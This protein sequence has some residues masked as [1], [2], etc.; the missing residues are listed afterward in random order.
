MTTTRAREL[1]YV[2]SAIFRP[3]LALVASTAHMLS[4]RCLELHPA[5]SM[6]AQPDRAE[7]AAAMARSIASETR[8]ARAR[9]LLC[10]RP[11]VTLFTI[12]VIASQRGRAFHLSAALH[13]RVP[14]WSGD[15]GPEWLRGVSGDAAIDGLSVYYSAEYLRIPATL[16]LWLCRIRSSLIVELTIYY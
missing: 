9:R 16:H 3:A 7:D 1:A 8:R 5:C 14:F 13:A 10:T 2:L 15:S 11:L 4:S 6:H 12:A